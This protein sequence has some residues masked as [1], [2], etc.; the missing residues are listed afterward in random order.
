MK[1]PYLANK[2]KLKE[3]EGDPPKFNI[4]YNKLRKVS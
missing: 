1:F 4:K 3:K 2:F